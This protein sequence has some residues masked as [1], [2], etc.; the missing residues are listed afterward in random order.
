[1]VERPEEVYRSVNN[2]A[3]DLFVY[4]P[5][6]HWRFLSGFGTDNDLWPRTDTGLDRAN[7]SWHGYFSAWDP[8]GKYPLMR[9]GV[10]DYREIHPWLLGEST[11]ELRQ[12]SAVNSRLA[13]VEISGSP[14]VEKRL[15]DLGYLG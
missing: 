10:V 14:E 5:D 8:T 7:H 6:L 3:P 4:D 2:V 13:S 15:R 12:P 9:D 1:L 11:E